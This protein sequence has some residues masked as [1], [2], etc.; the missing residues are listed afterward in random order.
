[1]CHSVPFVLFSLIV[2]YNNSGGEFYV[3]RRNI[4]QLVFYSIGDTTIH[5]RIIDAGSGTTEL[6]PSQPGVGF[7]FIIGVPN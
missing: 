2:L 6:T 4:R 5:R 7:V 1:M 3:N